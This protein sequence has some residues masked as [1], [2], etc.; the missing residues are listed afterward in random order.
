MRVRCCGPISHHDTRTPPSHLSI[1]TSHNHLVT[2]TLMRCLLM[3]QRAQAHCRGS[4]RREGHAAEAAARGA[5]VARSTADAERGPPPPSATRVGREVL[6]S[7][8]VVG[9]HG[10]APRSTARA[11]AA[12]HALAPDGAS[13]RST[14]QAAR[15]ACCMRFAHATYTHGMPVA[16]LRTPRRA[17]MHNACDEYCMRRWDQRHARRG[18]CA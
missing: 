3:R 6:N 10:D 2:T 11:R 7:H 13:G 15:C 14:L 16:V 8:T 12:V 4:G 18:T 5:G 9:A 1:R 17:R